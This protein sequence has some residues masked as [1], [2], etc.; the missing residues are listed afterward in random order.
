MEREGKISVI[1]LTYNSELTVEETLD[2][3]RAQTFRDYEII[4]ADDASKDH[5]VERVERW[6]SSN[7]EIAAQLICSEVNRGIPHNCNLGIYH[8]SGKVIK[9]L[10]GDDILRPNALEDYY[11][12]YILSDEKCIIQA[13]SKAFGKKKEHVSRQD[14]HFEHCYKL[15]ESIN[16]E[17]QLQALLKEYYLITPSIGLI[18]KRI[19]V[20][21]ECFDERFPM[22]EDYPFYLKLLEMDYYVTLID[23]TLVDYRVS[24]SSVSGNLSKKYARSLTSFFFQVKQKKLF[25]K[26][27]YIELAHQ[28]IFYSYIYLKYC[29]FR[30]R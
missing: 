9:I 25:H 13:K 1:V 27:M 7:K 11:K 20:E 15:L 3:I 14:M 5:T 12:A 23:K 19:F 29:L 26:A 17:E 30:S 16:R 2:S 6:I 22:L 8:A 28:F 10:A 24:D 21:L 18:E 4:V